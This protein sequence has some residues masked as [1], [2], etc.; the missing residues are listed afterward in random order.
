MDISSLPKLARRNVLVLA[1]CLVGLAMFAVFALL[2]N[3]HKHRH[4]TRAVNELQKQIASQKDMNFLYRKLAEIHVR[5]GNGDERPIVKP[6]P[7]SAHEAEQIVLTMQ[8]LADKEGIV[9]N[10]VRPELV[11]GGMLSNQIRVQ[12]VLHGQLEGHR[13]F[14]LDLLREPYVEGMEDL[15]LE[16]NGNGI[17]LRI[18][19]VV[20]IA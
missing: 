11:T 18:V 14:L 4:Q 5:Q 9:L 13:A 15:V 19:V 2:P 12:A 7:L 16:T 1:G 17:E 3:I 8:K 10:D 20:N 6:Q